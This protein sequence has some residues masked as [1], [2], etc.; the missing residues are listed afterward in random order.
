MSEYPI[1]ATELRQ[2]LTDVI[3]QVREENATY[4]VETFGRPQVVIMSLEAYRELQR[5]GRQAR[6]EQK[7]LAG[8]SFG[9][10]VDRPEL[11]DDWLA[12]GRAQWQSDWRDADSDDG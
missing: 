3:Q 10:W 11:D 12:A 9:L 5:A 2:K 7:E 8:S 1:G 6:S 4:I